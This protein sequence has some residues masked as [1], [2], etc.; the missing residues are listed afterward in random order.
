MVDLSIWWRYS[1]FF[2]AFGLPLS[3]Y[4]KANAEDIFEKPQGEKVE[5]TSTFFITPRDVKQNYRKYHRIDHS[6]TKM[7]R[8]TM[9]ERHNYN[10]QDL[11]NHWTAAQH[12]FY[13]LPQHIGATYG[14]SA[15]DFYF[16]QPQDIRYYYTHKAYA[17][18]NIVLANLGSFVFNGCYTQRLL[19]N[20]HIGTHWYG[21]MTEK[22]WPSHNKDDKIVNAFPSFDIF[23]HIKSSDGSYHLFTSWSNMQY[24]TRETGG[25]RFHNNNK[26]FAFKVQDPSQRYKSSFP[27][28][29]EEH[30]KNKIDKE[31]QVMHKDLRRHFYLYHH[32]EF[33][34]PLQ[35]YHELDYN[36]KAN[37]CTIEKP[38]EELLRF[39]S[40]PRYKAHNK[41][42]N[43]V[44]MKSFGNEIGIK[45]A[46]E[47]PHLFYAAYY[48]L[49]AIDL[50]YD[51]SKLET[52]PYNRLLKAQK[53]EKEQYLGGYTRWYFA[54][55]SKLHLDGAYLLQKGG[56][57]KLNV[58]YQ[59]KF[60]KVSCHTIKHKTPYIVTYGYSRHRPWNKNFVTPSTRAIDAEVWY[61]WSHIAIHP[62]LSFKKLNNHIYYKKAVR[63]DNDDHCIAE[64]MQAKT[65][66][67]L[68]YLEGNVNF[69]FFSYFHFDH[70]LTLILKESNKGGKIFTGYV[71][72]YMYTGRYYFAHQ[73]YDKNMDI[74]TGLNIHFKDLY[75]GDG[76]DVIAQQFYR[77]NKFAVQGRPIVDV[78]CNVRINHLKLSLKWS[79]INEYFNKPRGYFATPFYPSPKKAADIG[80]Q[81]SFFD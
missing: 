65:P 61:N 11:G 57:H 41:E 10:F 20:W 19:E 37:I 3:T 43:S 7:D 50:N 30:M 4:G 54:K 42:D 34:K 45:R 18:F 13:R 6:I 71:P 75:Y 44:V 23:T 80:I 8:F 15:Y 47:H 69:C 70:N 9:A 48:R 81:W 46:I 38:D 56:Y 58:A 17:Y 29:E 53:E 22:E 33:S 63:T 5:A 76:Y 12:I 25:V 21:A 40:D 73:P 67:Y 60:F 36:R 49:E 55:H 68:L 14:L 52:L 32:Y 78:F 1:L 16:Q 66:I 35:L 31:K 77:Q 51:F 79:Y 26:E 24:V 39:I 27:L 74:E 2:L 28:L 72:P 62:I 59:Q 64:P